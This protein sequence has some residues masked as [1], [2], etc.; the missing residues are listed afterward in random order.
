M[1]KKIEKPI[2]LG[3][4]LSL[5]M[6]GI[7]ASFQPSGLPLATAKSATVET[8]GGSKAMEAGINFKKLWATIRR[9]AAC[10]WCFG[11][12]GSDSTACDVCKNGV[13]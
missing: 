6:A 1:M 4:F 13:K 11:S 5:W 7:I 3:L 10:A 12:I 8:T 9:G 2:L